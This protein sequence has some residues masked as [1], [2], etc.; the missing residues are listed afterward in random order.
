M[1]GDYLN[2]RPATGVHLRVHE[3]PQ[4]FIKGPREEGF[5]ASLQIEADSVVE[6]VEVDG[7]FGGCS[8]GSWRQTSQRSNPMIEPG[9][10]TL[11]VLSRVDP[12]SEH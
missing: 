1:Y 4:A 12:L 9:L 5:S 3:Y 8:A 2:T 10:S 6:K 7:F 11:C